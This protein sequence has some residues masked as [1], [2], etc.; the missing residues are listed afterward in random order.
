MSQH[1]YLIVDNQ[2]VLEM[3]MDE[4]ITQEVREN[5]L[6][7]KS[8]DEEEPEPSSPVLLTNAL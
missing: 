3:M 8:D 4:E 2:V 7:N 6:P 1:L 5:A